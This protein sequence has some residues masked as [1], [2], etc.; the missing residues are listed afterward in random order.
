[1]VRMPR[2]RSR[3]FASSWRRGSARRPRADATARQTGQSTGREER[4]E[5]LTDGT[6]R[7]LI[8]RGEGLPLER[9]VVRA[10]DGAPDGG[11]AGCGHAQ[12]PD[13]EAYQGQRSGGIARHLTAHRQLDPGPS[14]TLDCL[15]HE[16]EHGGMERILVAR[17]LAVASID[18]N[19][20]LEQI[21]RAEAREPEAAE[22]RIADEGGGREL[23]HDPPQ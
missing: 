7:G 14:G 4:L 23:Q 12:L 10:A 20:V 8:E 2:R 3:R 1:M 13:A 6:R 19:R 11:E 17:Q 22:V 9:R 16:A 5:A 21:V 15:A 18:G